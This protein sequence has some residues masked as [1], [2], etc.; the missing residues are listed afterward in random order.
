LAGTYSYTLA[1][2]L[3]Q[4][5][6]G[7]LLPANYSNSFNLAAFHVTAAS[8]S[9]QAMPGTDHVRITF[10]RA[11]DPAAVDASAFHLTGPGST[12]VPITSVVVVGGTGNTQYDVNFAAL[13]TLGAYSLTVM[14]LTDSYGNTLV[15]FT[16]NFTVANQPLVTNGGFETGTFMGWTQSGDTGATGVGRAG[17]LPS[18]GRPH[19]GTY[20]AYFGPTGALGFITQ[21]IPTVAGSTY[22]LDF[23]LA[24]PY[25]D[26]GSRVEWLV[27]LG[28]TTLMD[29]T[30]PANF[31]Y[32]EFHFTFTATGPTAL[33]FGFLEPPS[34][35]FLDD[36]SVT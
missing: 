31:D 30:D 36:V 3:I 26:T 25:S 9:G 32:T 29:V 35:F 13:T 28:S 33:Q 24:H 17:T 7:N 12:T 16:D 34:Y 18:P 6:Y 27:R 2:G 4:D 14:G 15:P 21:T 10:D 5:P 19:S 8:P 11:E 20:A 1:S 23:W 22:T